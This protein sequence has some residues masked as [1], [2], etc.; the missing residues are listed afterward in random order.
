MRTTSF[1]AI[2]R[3]LRDVFAVCSGVIALVSFAFSFY[4]WMHKD[5]L[6]RFSTTD[7]AAWAL[8]SGVTAGTIMT[9]WVWMFV[10][11]AIRLARERNL[12]LTGWLI[13]LVVF[14][15]TAWVYYF[16]QYRSDAT[17]RARPRR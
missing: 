13:V 2:G 1:P 11:C 14:W 4:L 15:P 3:T 16:T 6:H 5:L 7:R 12:Y 17:L 9:M 8:I 10:N